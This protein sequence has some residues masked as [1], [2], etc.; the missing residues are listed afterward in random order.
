LQDIKG[1]KVVI[2]ARVSTV[3]QA[4]NEVSIHDQI[5]RVEQFVT[6]RGGVVVDKRIE[7]GA[8]ATNTARPEYQR[9]IADAL[10]GKFEVI[11]AF[12]LSRLF[13]NAL[14]YLQ[15]R[16]QL[17]AAGIK[18]VS[19]TQDFADDPTGELALSMVALFDEYQSAENAKH[20]KRTMLANAKAGYWNG[21]TPPI[22]YKTVS[23]PQPKGKD[24]KKLVIDEATA[25]LPRLIFETYVNGTLDGPI[26]IVR[27]AAFLNG[28]GETLRGRKFHV[29]NVHAILSNTA[30]VG[31]A[32][33]NKRCSKTR[34]ARPSEE[35]VPI[36]VPQLIPE[37][38]FYQAQAQMAARD[39]KM[40]RHAHKTNT[41]LLTSKVL[42]GT[43]SSN[44][45]GGGMT[46]ATGKSGL[47]SYY[48]C[49]T[50]RT[51]GKHFCKG[52]WVRMDDLDDLVVDKVIEQ[53]LQP[54][55][56]KGLLSS[57]LDQNSVAE[58]LDRNELKS[59]RS[60]LTMLDGESANVI[61]LVR[62]GLL[63]A[64]D[65]QIERELAQIA[66][67]KRAINADIELLERKLADPS[68]KITPDI[69]RRFGELVSGSLR[70]RGNPL[71]KGYVDLL[72]DKVEVGD[73]LIR[74]SGDR[75]RLARAAS[76]TPPHMVPKA[77]REW[78]TRQDSNL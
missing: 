44:G 10:D 35:W 18:L 19:V 17:R 60:R 24:R 55:R 16:A 3:R 53:V 23:V 32:F 78:R 37:D 68:R 47:H 66:S 62:K 20:V 6:A 57:W 21:Q 31:C 49:N 25:H 70:E 33:F 15:A 11:A 45:C 9:M 41:N 28:R 63:T 58:G 65:P 74:I 40:G 76:G 69:L 38:L 39:P 4:D 12:S 77:I 36:S 64:D 22:G 2:Y 51:S 27:L 72:V 71:R 30:Y 59:L 46:T 14:D 13:R 75:T 43:N 56:L 5:D 67:Q 34:A 42:C 8:S 54:D 61:G 50:R 52:R 7:P 73:D 29:S 1:K 48:S 26:G